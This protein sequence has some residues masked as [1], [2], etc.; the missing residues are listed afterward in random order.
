MPGTQPEARGPPLRRHQ[1]IHVNIQ[2]EREHIKE[3]IKEE[4][5]NTDDLDDASLLMQYFKKHDYDNNMK[6]DGLE[7]LKAL[8]HMEEDDHEHEDAS[9]DKKSGKEL[10]EDMIPIVDNI[11]LE[12]D[13]DKD[14]YISWPEF[15]SRQ[16]KKE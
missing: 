13:K 14:G 4:Y 6:L 10:T 3:H 8:S 7:L 12:D 5:L 9:E 16:N 1:N 2:E 11:L 15:M